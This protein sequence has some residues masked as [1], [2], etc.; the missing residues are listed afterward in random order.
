MTNRRIGEPGSKVHGF[1]YDGLFEGK[2]HIDGHI[3]A[4]DALKRYPISDSSL[5]V[6]DFHSVMYDG[7]DVVRLKGDREFPIGKLL[8]IIAMILFDNVIAVMILFAL[9]LSVFLCHLMNRLARYR[10]KKLR[11]V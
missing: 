3:Y 5:K 8:Y 1:I 6:Q 2:I 4:I 10:R 9:F 11:F 7:R